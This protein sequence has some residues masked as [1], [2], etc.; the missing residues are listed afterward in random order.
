MGLESATWVDDLVSTNPVTGDDVSV[1]DD[2][3][4]LIKAALKAT[5][6][7]ANKAFYFPSYEAISANE[8]V[9]VADE[10]KWYFVDTS[11]GNV[12]VTLPITLGTTRAGFRVWVQRGASASNSL[13]VAPASGTINGAAN[14]SVAAVYQVAEFIWSGTAWQARQLGA[15][16]VLD[17]VGTTQLEDNAVTPAKLSQMAVN[18]FI[19]NDNGTTQTP[20]HLTVAEATALLNAMVGDSGSGGTKGLVPAPDTG[21]ANKALTGNGDFVLAKDI[22]TTKSIGTAGYVYLPG[23]L[24][25]QWGYQVLAG[26]STVTITFPTAFP[27]ACR[28]FVSMDRIDGDTGGQ[29]RNALVRSAPTTTQVSL[30]TDSATDGLY[31]IAI[32]N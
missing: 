2:H 20:Q 21:D 1:G 23:G 18:G 11:G 5:F 30:S 14:I 15:L 4:R 27:T 28:A 13:T 19:G 3:I 22:D 7:S 31:W 24:L 6:P 16:S 26:G 17:T 10:N 25:V 32:G 12:A 9:A 8:T 29:D